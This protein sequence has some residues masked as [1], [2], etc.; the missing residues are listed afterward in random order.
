MGYDP[1]LYALVS[2]AAYH[3][4]LRASEGKLYKFLKYYNK[5]LGLLRTSLGLGEE[6]TEATLCTIHTLTTIEVLAYGEKPV[7]VHS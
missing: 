6:H 4:S 5:A 3:H 2:F 7:S 1:L